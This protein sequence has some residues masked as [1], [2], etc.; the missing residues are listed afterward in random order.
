VRDAE[1]K[2]LFRGAEPVALGQRAVALLH[3]LVERP[4]IPIS[5]DAL[6]EAAWPGL[7]VEESNLSVQIAA[8]RRVFGEKPGAEQWDRDPAETWLSVRWSPHA[9]RRADA[10]QKGRRAADQYRAIGAP[11]NCCKEEQFN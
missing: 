10:R 7:T 5:K 1:A 6:L 11:G 4:G 8:L 9:R 2:I 3:T